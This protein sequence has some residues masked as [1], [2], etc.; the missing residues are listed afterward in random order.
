MNPIQEDSISS[1]KNDKTGDDLNQSPSAMGNKIGRFEQGLSLTARFNLAVIPLLLLIFAVS[2]FVIQYQRKAS[3]EDQL[4]ILHYT[5]SNISHDQ[6]AFNQK[7]YRVG[8]ERIT[9]FLIEVS[10]TPLANNQYKI[11]DEVI[12]TAARSHLISYAAFFSHDNI[13]ISD[14]GK[15]AR[16]LRL[17]KHAIRK[18][19]KTLGYL[20]LGISDLSSILQ[21]NYIQS[22][23]EKQ[24]SQL[25]DF[26]FKV[27][28]DNRFSAMIAFTFLICAISFTA[29]FI[30]QRFITSPL[31][32][33]ISIMKQFQQKE[34]DIEI[35][36]QN[37][38]DEIGQIARSLEAFRIKLKELV[39]L[40][41]DTEAKNTQLIRAMA[42]AERLAYVDE[43]TNLPNRSCCKLDAQEVF[44]NADNNA[45]FALVYLD[46]ND[47]KRVNDTLG[48]AA[49]DSLLCE[50][51]KRLGILARSK[52]NSRVY[53]W[54]GD[55]FVLIYDR[56]N[57]ATEDF[58][59]EITKILG[60]QLRFGSHT[61]WPSGSLGIAKFPE[62]G[63]DFETLMI[64]A[65]LALHKTKLNSNT[66][67]FF[68][69]ELKEKVDEETRIESELRV[70]IEE[71]QLF[72]VYQPQ[73]DSKTQKVR[74]IEALIRWRHPERGVLSPYHFLDV[75]E[76]SRLAPI[77]GAYVFD[78]A[79]RAARSWLDN[80]LDF[81]R[82]AVNLSPKH[83]MHGTLIHDLAHAMKNCRLD[84]QYITVEVLESLLI[85]N[86]DDQQRE[87]ISD[88]SKMNV[89]IELDDFG[90]G[91]ASLSHLSTLPIDA[92]KVDRSFTNQILTDDR[93]AIVIQ[94]LLSLTK[95]LQIGLVC[96]GVETA[97]QMQK[98]QA[99]GNCSLQGYLIAKPMEFNDMTTWL[100]EEQN[101]HFLNI[102]QDDQAEK[103][104]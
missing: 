46:L 83:L 59:N 6:S 53:R 68:T 78:E 56:S 61:L 39:A 33:C 48:H 69:Q 5:F 19:D 42:E 66:Y 13:L 40:E 38:Q 16:H 67:H 22:T 43:L 50:V 37:K 45:C 74:G 21:S 71:K 23:A 54:G 52:E 3:F 92:L 30:F 102:H 12:K 88:L 80:G 63:S 34:Y 96:E 104:A 36:Y 77:V 57:G 44:S 20:V 35:P 90:T 98:I 103:T 70:A 84:S 97:S 31:A 29:Y 32:H 15:P 79:F 28:V 47:F 72:L 94:S 82:I 17:K 89:H 14:T 58:C 27:Q 73:I 41:H 49:G 65:D 4:Q 60:T 76:E 2:A 8:E 75:I 9:N 51:G 26:L 24:V 55:E 64:N 99:Y 100:E 87:F 93:K 10:K 85:D 7:T 95:L 25:R 1:S 11:L 62:D 101:L 86:N 18:D 81:G 91:Y